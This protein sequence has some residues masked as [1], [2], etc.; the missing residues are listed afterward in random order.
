[1]TDIFTVVQLFLFIT[2]GILIGGTQFY[3][4]SFTIYMHIF[5]EHRR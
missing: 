2:F 1:M 3:F 5:N 4:Q